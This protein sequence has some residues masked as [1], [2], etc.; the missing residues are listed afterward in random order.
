MV[1]SYSVED[2]NILSH[3]IHEYNFYTKIDEM[4]DITRLTQHTREAA[5]GVNVGSKKITSYL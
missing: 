2:F 1:D 3:F 4:L 5:N